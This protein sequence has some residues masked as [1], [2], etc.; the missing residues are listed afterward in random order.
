M[1]YF[2][3]G[4]GYDS[5]PV[6]FY[7]RAQAAGFNYVLAEFWLESATWNDSGRY[8]WNATSGLRYKLRDEF[9]RADQHG[10]K[11]IPLIQTSSA[12]SSHWTQVKNDSIQWQRLPPNIPLSIISQAVRDA[13]NN[14]VPTFAP[15]PP[16]VFGFDSSFNELLNVIYSAFNAAKTSTGFSY[17]NLDYIHFGGDEPIARFSILGTRKTIVL[18]G[19]CR[20]DSAWLLSN[21]LGGVGVQNQII[22]LLGSNIKRKVRMIADAGRRQY[23]PQSTKGLYYGDMLDPNHL[24]GTDSLCAFSN[25]FSTTSYSTTPIKTYG[26]A[27]NQYVQ[28]MKDSSIVVQWNYEKK[29]AYSGKSDYDTDSTFRYFTH[30]S[31]KFLHGNALADENQPITPV[32]MHQFMEQAVAGTRPEFNNYVK[33]FV[34]FHWCSDPN[35]FSDA[36]PIY[37]QVPSYK[38]MEFLSHLLWHNAALLE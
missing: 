34:S 5:I 36:K 8:R 27:S 19:L 22:A 21:L 4:L 2:G 9:V 20:R 29:N 11:L 10:L 24:G 38:T 31:L 16:G 23:P 3:A 15:D 13:F 37:G 14:K 30:K 12:S 1:A 17:S 7:K 35:T 6:G 26:L 18:A 32:R 28:D 25:L 33:G